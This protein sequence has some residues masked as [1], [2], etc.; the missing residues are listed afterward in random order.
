MVKRFEL[1][2]PV[3]ATPELPF[4]LPVLAS[5]ELVL[6]LLVVAVVFT[7]ELVLGKLVVAT[8]V[9]EIKLAPNVSVIV[10]CIINS[11]K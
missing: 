6:G 4:E 5:P 3:L 11:N 9:V 1:T 8:V 2:I 7:F 10:H